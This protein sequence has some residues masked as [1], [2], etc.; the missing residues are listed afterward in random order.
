MVEILPPQRGTN[1]WY[2]GQR[3]LL[4]SNNAR[5]AVRILPINGAK[6]VFSPL[7]PMSVEIQKPNCLGYSGLEGSF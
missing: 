3:K 4:Y 5:L 1:E 2:R 7:L 6:T